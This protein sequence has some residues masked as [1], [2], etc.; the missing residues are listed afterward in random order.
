MLDYNSERRP[1]DIAIIFIV[2]LV[3]YGYWDE[4]CPVKVNGG[5]GAV[6]ATAFVRKGQ[7][8]YIPI[9]NFAA[10]PGTQSV[11]SFGLFKWDFFG[12]RM[13]GAASRQ[14]NA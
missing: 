14:L 6:L 2:S 12:L 5:D 4:S 1:G 8:A 13:N 11:T 9:A 3:R 10:H 7:T